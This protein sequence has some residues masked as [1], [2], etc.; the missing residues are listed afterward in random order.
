MTLIG[1]GKRGG[2]W[3]VEFLVERRELLREKNLEAGN[4]SSGCDL[5]ATF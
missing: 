5:K 2:D 4:R 3:Y 1:A